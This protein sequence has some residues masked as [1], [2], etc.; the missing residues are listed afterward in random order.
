MM[1]AWAGS[2]PTLREPDLTGGAA[3]EAREPHG[4]AQER[5]SSIESLRAQV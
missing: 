2:R 1:F 4:H 3:G 5:F